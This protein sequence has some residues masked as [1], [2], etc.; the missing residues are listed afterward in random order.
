MG[1]AT[2]TVG[3][4]A[5]YKVVGISQVQESKTNPRKHFAKDALSDLTKS[6]AEKGVLDPLLV[7]PFPA[8]SNELADYEIVAGARRFRAAK[9]AGKIALPVV[10][11]NFTDEEALEVQLIEN[12]QRQDVHP[13]EEAEGY[14]QLLAKA[15]YEIESL[16]AKV[17]KSISYIYQRLKL[18]ELVPAAKKA[19]E[20]EKITAG[21]AI[22]LARLQPK[23]Q[24]AVLKQSTRYAGDVCSVRYMAHHIQESVHL[25]LK[26]VP[27]KL[28]DAQLDTKAGPCTTCPKRSS[29]SPALFADIAKD[30]VCTDPTCFENKMQAHLVRIQTAMKADGKKAVL[31][32]TTSYN[33]P[34]GALASDKWR[35][36]AAGSCEHVLAGL[37]VGSGWHFGRDYRRGTATSICTERTCKVHWDR[38]ASYDGGGRSYQDKAKE[39]KTKA[40]EAARTEAL[41]QI[42]AKVKTFD[43]NAAAV[44][45]AARTAFDSQKLACT[46]LGVWPKDGKVGGFDFR[47]K[48][49]AHIKNTAKTPRALHRIFAVLSLLPKYGR[50]DD[51]Y[52]QSEVI[53]ALRKAG[54][55]VGVNVEKLERKYVAEANAK[56]KKRAKAK[57]KAK[58]K[59]PA[60]SQ[61]TAK[62]RKAKKT[63]KAA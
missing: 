51:G 46:I 48:L 28:D 11:R 19:F 35:G 52:Y 25:Q 5:E 26:A 44:R 10:V 3:A 59:K 13:L 37:F 56:A 29:N 33:P 21:H 55:A 1:T 9:A 30:D 23:D 62:P 12:L 47:D 6:I 36:A 14:K 58:A 34:K 38:G 63:K 27:W 31:I 61:T 17:G 2:A 8:N 15:G 32:A 42:A 50:W 22:L 60:K 20:E 39:R 53:P 49:E 16:A 43:L 18:S 45:F 7:R 54:K 4:G 40:L 57:S 24:I 41:R